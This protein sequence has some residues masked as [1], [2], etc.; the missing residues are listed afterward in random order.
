MVAH[1]YKIGHADEC[2]AAAQRSVLQSEPDPAGS[3]QGSNGSVPGRCHG[4]LWEAVTRASPVIGNPALAGYCHGVFS[5]LTV[6][7][8]PSFRVSRIK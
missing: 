2:R 7:K 3:F 8:V 4:R 6:N 1:P 5:T